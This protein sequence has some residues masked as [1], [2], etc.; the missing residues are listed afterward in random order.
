[1]TAPVIDLREHCLTMKRITHLPFLLT[2]LLE[3]NAVLCGQQ[4]DQRA[5]T[6]ALESTVADA[7]DQASDSI[8]AVSRIKNREAAKT[9]N[10]VRGNA[11]VA[12][13][14]LRVDPGFVVNQIPIEDIESFD[15]A[16]GVVVGGNGEILTTFHSVQLA[17]R[18]VVRA[19]NR[20]TFDAEIIAADP[21]SDLTIIAPKMFDGQQ[22]PKL[23]PVRI[24]RS[25]TLRRGAFLVALGNPFNAARD[26]RPSAAFGILANTARR[27]DLTIDESTSTGRQLR[28]LP[29][30]L[31]LDSKLNLGMSGGAVLNMNGELVGITTNGGNPQGFDAQA[32]YAIPMDT[33]GRRAVGTLLQGE[34]VEYGFLGVSL[35]TNGS[36]GIQG[37]SPGTPAFSAGLVQGD[38][39]VKIGEMPVSD[40]DQLVLAV[41]S[42]PVETPLSIT[43]V[44]PGFGNTP[45]IEKKARVRLAKFPV[46][47]EVI[48]T[49]KPAPWRGIMVDYPSVAIQGNNVLDM[50]TLRTNP[51]ETDGALVVQIDRDSPG[52]QMLKIGDLIVS[53]NDKAVK[54]P[55]EFRDAVKNLKGPVRIR[56]SNSEFNLPE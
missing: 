33:L 45:P 41:N 20:Q 12:E 30:L 43:F 9:T 53:V 11:L 18:I 10:A 27:L 23:K 54:T 51:A 14:N 16:A 8:V 19:A 7:I 36:N 56:T 48:A 21:R 50:P 55:R 28:H 22:L 38:Q 52:F 15:Y 34:E 49:N 47:G 4:I 3:F 17:D 37:V 6:A 26:G 42:F 32:G 35:S 46:G 39:I 24:G 40:G 1:M 5:I 25:E 44:R 2:L 29:T 31:Q 13:K